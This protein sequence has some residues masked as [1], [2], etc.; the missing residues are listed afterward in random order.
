[1]TWAPYF[2]LYFAAY[3]FLTTRV[4]GVP[5]GEQPP[6]AIALPCGLLAGI[7]AAGGL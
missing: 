3:E 7:G 2:S 6:V 1:M 4:C 5:V